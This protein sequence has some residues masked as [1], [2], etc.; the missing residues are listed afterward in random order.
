MKIEN[1]V[2]KGIETALAELYNYT[3]SEGQIQIQNT[4]KDLEGD[5]TVVVFPFL[6]FSKKS[7]EKRAR[8]SEFLFRKISIL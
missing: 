6:R 3:P 7:P 2:Q 8:R 4:R 1:I 5:V